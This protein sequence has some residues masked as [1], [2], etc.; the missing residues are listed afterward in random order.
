MKYLREMT[1]EWSKFPIRFYPIYYSL[2][3]VLLKEYLT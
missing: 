3:E 2:S 1:A